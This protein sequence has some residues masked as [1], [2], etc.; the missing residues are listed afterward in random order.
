MKGI[1][2]YNPIEN[3][4]DVLFS[5]MLNLSAVIAITDMSHLLSGMEL[6][7]TVVFRLQK[8]RN[9]MLL[10]HSLLLVL[11][12][13]A[14]CGLAQAATANGC[15]IKAK[16]IQQQIDY[17]KQHGNTQRVAGL[18]TALKEVKSNCTEA[19][20]QAEHQQKVAQKQ[21]KVAERQQE[22]KQAQETGDAKKIAKKQKKLDEAQTELKQ[23]Q[24]E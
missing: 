22:L 3:L 5:A 20:L 9:I 13:V 12:V 2:Q 14:F 7:R 6:R 18:E 24:A 19:G 8:G 17:A 21:Q 11:P 1:P 10:R 4:G 15:D 16:E 23:L